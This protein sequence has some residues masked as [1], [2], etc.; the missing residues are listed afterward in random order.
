MPQLY[1]KQDIVKELR[2]KEEEK[3]YVRKN[4]EGEPEI[5][6]SRVAQITEAVDSILPVKLQMQTKGRFKQDYDY[7]FILLPQRIIKVKGS[8]IFQKIIPSDNTNGKIL[9]EVKG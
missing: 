2:I 9:A 5:T 7:I 4:G 1:I 6:F 3:I 8:K